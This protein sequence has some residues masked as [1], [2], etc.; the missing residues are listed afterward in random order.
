MNSLV[1]FTSNAFTSLFFLKGNL[2]RRRRWGGAAVSEARASLIKVAATATMR[3]HL[4]KQLIYQNIYHLQIY[5][6]EKMV[7]VH[8]VQIVCYQHL[9]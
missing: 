4:L 1:L 5:G 3:Y 7:L 8:H 6:Q 9:I 2:H